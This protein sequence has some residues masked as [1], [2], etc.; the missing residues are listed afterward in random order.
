[1]GD[2]NITKSS[3][4]YKVNCLICNLTACTSTYNKNKTILVVRY[5]PH[6]LVPTNFTG[7]RY[8]DKSLQVIKEG[9]GL[10]VREKRVI[11]LIIAGIMAAISAIA[12]MAMASMALSQSTQN[13]HYVNTPRM[14]PMPSNK[15]Q[16]KKKLMSA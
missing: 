12:T 14:S 5:I 7:I 13:A 6:L 8:H 9:K 4:I 3:S 11:G 10:L 1:M 2:L 16:K 15:C